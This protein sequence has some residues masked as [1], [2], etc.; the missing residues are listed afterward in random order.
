M[1]RE[2][3]VM[4]IDANRKLQA[5]G[6]RARIEYDDSGAML[7]LYV[8]EGEQRRP[9]REQDG[10]CQEAQQALRAVSDHR[11]YERH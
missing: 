6:L 8:H 11:W 7:Q 5:M 4:A 2:Q 3:K 1:S 10:G 9:L